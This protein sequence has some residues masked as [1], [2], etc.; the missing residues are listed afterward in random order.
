MTNSQVESWGKVVQLNSKTT[1]PIVFN[2]IPTKFLVV[3]PEHLQEWEAHFAKYVGL[4]PNK[5]HIA[6]LNPH[7]EWSGDPKETI[8]GSNEDWDDSDYW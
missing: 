5:Q 8:S 7:H 6:K 4:P 3:A 2:F 1:G